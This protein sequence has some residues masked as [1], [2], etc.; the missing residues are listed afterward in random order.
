MSEKDN[1]GRI[2][3][4]KNKEN[5]D[6]VDDNRMVISTNTDTDNSEYKMN[7]N[8]QNGEKTVSKTFKSPDESGLILKFIKWYE[9]YTGESVSDLV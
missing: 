4:L 6:T 9:N 8:I 3:D 5:V 2:K 7:V 1:Y